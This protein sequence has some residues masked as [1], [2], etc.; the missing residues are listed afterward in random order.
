[1]LSGLPL[2]LKGQEEREK[3]GEGG[4]ERGREKGGQGGREGGW[5]IPASLPQRR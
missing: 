3:E 4:R 1:M 2:D 5:Y